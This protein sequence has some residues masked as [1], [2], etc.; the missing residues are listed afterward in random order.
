[1]SL[2]NI[3]SSI[4]QVDPNVIFTDGFELSNQTTIPKEFY[5]G[6]FT[7]NLN[8]IEFYIY[9]QGVVQ[10]SDYNFSNYQITENSDPNQG[11]QGVSVDQNAKN[12]FVQG[13]TT[14]I[15][16]LHPEYDVYNTGS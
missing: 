16:N 8:N 5:S 7:P 11:P 6:S 9:S 2:L 15:V 3:S 4:Q 14:N 12:V 1:M 10:Y 13:D